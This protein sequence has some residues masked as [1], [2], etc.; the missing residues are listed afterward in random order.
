MMCLCDDRDSSGVT[1]DHAAS[2]DT[3]RYVSRL[4]HGILT[5]V[6]LAAQVQGLMTQ[7]AKDAL[8]NLHM[9]PAKKDKM[10]M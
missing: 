10:D 4:C 6:A 9:K 5:M 3:A 2:S 7:V 8:F 1:S